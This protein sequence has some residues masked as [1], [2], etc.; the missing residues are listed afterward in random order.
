M[1]CEQCQDMTIF[2]KV[3]SALN[4]QPFA[5]PYICHECSKKEAWAKI[6]MR[7]KVALLRLRDMAEATALPSKEEFWQIMRI[8]G[9]YATSDI[10]EGL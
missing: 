2:E 7:V 10:P 3:E 9:N 8:T 6:E 5:K 4:G 1:S